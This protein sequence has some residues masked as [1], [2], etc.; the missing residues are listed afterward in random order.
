MFYITPI[1]VCYKTLW[2]DFVEWLCFKCQLVPSLKPYQFCHC[3]KPRKLKV[4]H[5]FLVHQGQLWTVVDRDNLTQIT[6]VKYLL[7]IQVKN[8]AIFNLLASKNIKISLQRYLYRVQSMCPPLLLSVSLTPPKHCPTD[9]LTMFCG[10]LSNYLAQPPASN[11]GKLKK[12]K[13]K[14]EI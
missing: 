4:T 3:L 1:Y 9:C 6:V 5:F 7:I 14:R 2:S 13:L 10:F 12:K 11:I 8:C